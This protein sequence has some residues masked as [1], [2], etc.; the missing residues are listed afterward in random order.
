MLTSLT[1]R[2]IRNSFKNNIIYDPTGQLRYQTFP[3]QAG[4]SADISFQSSRLTFFLNSIMF[5]RL[6]S[7]ICDCHSASALHSSARIV[8]DL[9][10]V[11]VQVE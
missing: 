8:A 9:A 4:V 5:R 7:S 1:I 11:R 2:T 3:F 6:T 10:E